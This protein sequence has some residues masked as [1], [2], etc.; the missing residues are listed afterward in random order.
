[1]GRR[2]LRHLKDGGRRRNLRQ[3]RHRRHLGRQSDRNFLR[4]ER[5]G[6]VLRRQRDEILSESSE[7]CERLEALIFP[8]YLIRYSRLRLSL[9]VVVNNIFLSLRTESLLWFRTGPR[10]TEILDPVRGPRVTEPSGMKFNSR[11]SDVVGSRVSSE[12]FL[13][14]MPR[15]STESL[16]LHELNVLT[17][18]SFGNSRTARSRGHGRS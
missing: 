11:W 10:D 4:R 5:N 8:M 16:R 7:G 9:F 17:L 18:D 12:A 2:H 6:R 13:D 15:P 14:L 1:M 3:V